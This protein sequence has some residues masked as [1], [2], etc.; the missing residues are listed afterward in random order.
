MIELTQLIFIEFSSGFFLVVAI[1]VV[2]SVALRPLR[3]LRYVWCMVYGLQLS[4]I[5]R[6]HRDVM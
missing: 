1:V 3:P 2:A 4:E 6:N 5:L